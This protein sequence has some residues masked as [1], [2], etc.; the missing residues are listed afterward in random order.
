MS[1]GSLLW[2]LCLRQVG[3]SGVGPLEVVI[4]SFHCVVLPAVLVFASAITLMLY[5][6]MNNLRRYKTEFNE[7]FAPEEK[8]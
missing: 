1:E 3:R 2:R 5:R 7:L 4:K 6:E 8:H